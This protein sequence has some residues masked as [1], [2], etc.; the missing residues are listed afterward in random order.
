MI[1][2]TVIYEALADVFELSPVAICISTAEHVSRYI[3]AN[4]A[5]L[6]MIGRSW[7]E[8]EGQPMY[9]DT[10]RALDSPERLRRIHA[11]ETVGLYELEEIDLRHVS[12]RII[13]TL[14]ST[15]RRAINGQTFDIEI[16]IDNSERKAFERRIIEAAYTDVVT[17]LPNRAAFDNRLRK[18]LEQF[19][20]HEGICLAYID[21]NGFKSI[22]DRHGHSIGDRVLRSFAER[23]RAH[24]APGHF[25]A[26]I[27]GDEFVRLH[28]FACGLSPEHGG[29]TGG[30]T[31]EEMQMLADA[32]C[33]PMDIEGRNLAVGAA[34]GVT[35]TRQAIGADAL[36]RRA[37]TLMY[38][39]KSTG[40]TVA[41]NLDR[42]D[43]PCPF[44]SPTPTPDVSS[45]PG[46]S[47]ATP[48][49]R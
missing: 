25:V 16:I 11:L 31:G 21:L 37:D 45:S 9:L 8:I 35:V 15:Q 14:V 6:A 22:N 33:A 24:S 34:I 47:S 42:I 19:T 2:R 5:Y 28:S 3:M 10:V 26:R 17:G 12:G 36:L 49:E 40:R 30:P 29:P 23:L 7:E 48:A 41:V 46:S 20:P 43:D 13:P 1:P 18:L 32:L 4:P 44:A 39:A 38:A 27:G